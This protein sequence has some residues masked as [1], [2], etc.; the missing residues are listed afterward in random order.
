M[1]EWMNACLMY[2][3]KISSE[4]MFSIQG[5]QY[6]SQFALS[7]YLNTNFLRKTKLHLLCFFYLIYLIFFI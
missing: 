3:L 7:A 1:D 6:Y 2:S 5:L 4:E